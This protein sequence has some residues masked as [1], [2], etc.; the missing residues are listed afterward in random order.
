MGALVGV[1]GPKA[2]VHVV[3]SSTDAAGYASFAA[4]DER[5]SIVGWTSVGM[6]VGTN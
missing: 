1:M 5:L 3:G 2:A 4:N 6:D